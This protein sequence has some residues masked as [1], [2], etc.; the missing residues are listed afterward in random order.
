MS[1]LIDLTGERFGRLIVV[2]RCRNGN[3]GQPRWHC[4]CDCG[5]FATVH[6]QSLRGGNAKSCGCLNRE[7]LKAG[8][9]RTHGASKSRLYSIWQTMKKRVFDKSRKDYQH[10]GGRGIDVCDEWLDSFEAFRDW[11]Y[12]SGYS[13]DKSIDRADNEKGYSSHNCR[14]VDAI[15]QANNKRNNRYITFNGVT[16]TVS[17]WAREINGNPTIIRDRIDR[18][19]WSVE[20]ALTTP[21]ESK[22]KV[23]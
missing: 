18:L 7:L 12:A 9:N 5:C 6:G 11:A 3:N 21:V 16:K 14:W 20:K 4:R 17:E 19:G 8:R 22:V 1:R 15:T 23:G 10:Y 2:S 13:D